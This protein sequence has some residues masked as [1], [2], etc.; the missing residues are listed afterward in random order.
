MYRII[1]LDEKTALLITIIVLSIVFGSRLLIRGDYIGFTIVSLAAT[2]G[3]IPHELAHR[4]SARKMNCYSRYVL[5][6]FGLIIT[7]ITAIPYIPFKI[8]M[9]GYT[10]IVPQT[11]DPVYL[12]K[13]NGLVSYFGPLTNICIASFS[14]ITYTLLLKYLYEYNILSIFLITSS[15]L[16]SWIALFNLLPIPPLDGSK[17]ISWKPHVW[18]T[19][20]LLSILIWIITSIELGIL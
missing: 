7:L 19:S 5:D 1:E 6:P 9:P 20:L 17:I 12:K 18:I 2:I 4:W 15:W 11:H 3:V 14:L 16:N 10:V 13:I 8:I